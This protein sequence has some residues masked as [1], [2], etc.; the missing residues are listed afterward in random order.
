L[1]RKIFLEII[2]T[3]QKLSK[4]KW[5]LAIPSLTLCDSEQIDV[6]L[7]MEHFD[8]HDQQG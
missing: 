4:T 8:I 5:Y 1:G 2:L 6:I 7:P 3:C